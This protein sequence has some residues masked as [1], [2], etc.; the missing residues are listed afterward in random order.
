MVAV[1]G[2]SAGMH[3]TMDYKTEP[4]TLSVSP[5]LALPDVSD[6]GNQAIACLVIVFEL[7]IVPELLLLILLVLL[8]L[9]LPSTTLFSLFSQ[10]MCYCVL[11]I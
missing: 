6:I 8:A 3:E 4:T 10:I 7:V 11:V 1:L 2:Y 9:L 5:N